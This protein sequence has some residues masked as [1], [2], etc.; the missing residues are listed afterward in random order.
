MHIWLNS[1]VSI[2]WPTRSLILFFDCACVFS[3]SEIWQARCCINNCPCNAGLAAFSEALVSDV[4]SDMPRS[5]LGCILQ[6]TLRNLAS[7]CGHALIRCMCWDDSAEWDMTNSTEAGMEY[8]FSELKSSIQGSGT[9]KDAILAAQV[10][11]LSSPVL[12]MRLLSS[13]H[14]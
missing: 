4:C 8:Y 12:F 13:T 3:H 10:L 9:V 11:C 2:D 14:R 5:L 6:V 1:M 7:V